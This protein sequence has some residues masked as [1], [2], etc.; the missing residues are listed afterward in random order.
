MSRLLTDFNR[1]GGDKDVFPNR[2]LS[3]ALVFLVVAV[4][5]AFATS[6]A[7]VAWAKA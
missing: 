4:T 2:K 1:T 5:S 6:A 7:Q 3:M